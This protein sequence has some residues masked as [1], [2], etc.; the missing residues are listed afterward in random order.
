MPPN[1]HP[2]DNQLT[3]KWHPSDTQ[4]TT[5]WH[6]CDTQM[7]PNGTQSDTQLTPEWHPNY[8]QM[9]R[10]VHCTASA[11]DLA[12]VARMTL[13]ITF[14]LRTS[15]TW[16]KAVKMATLTPCGAKNP[17]KNFGA[18]EVQESKKND[19]K[20]LWLFLYWLVACA[21]KNTTIGNDNSS[22]VWPISL[23]SSSIV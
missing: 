18:G 15:V 5:N 11:F 23:T 12:A 9:M 4:V 7:T 16:K 22:I 19:L 13:Y 2:S 8:T 14:L 21:L 10:C 1:R 3:P 6:P 20:H 17:I